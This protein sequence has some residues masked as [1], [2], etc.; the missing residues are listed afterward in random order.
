MKA[1]EF[2]A[3]AKL[4][5]DS[6]TLYVKG[7]F[8]APLNTKNKQRY[9][10]NNKY[11]ISRA[12]MINSASSDTFAFDCVCFIK[13]II[14]GWNADVN[15]QY[16]GAIYQSNNL[17]DVGVETLFN[18]C[19]NISK[20]FSGIVPGAMLYMTGH[21]GI[22]IGDGLAIEASPKWK[23][24]VQVTAVENVAK[25]TNYNSRSWLKWGKL[26]YVEYPVIDEGYEQFKK[27]MN[28]YLKE[29]AELPAD[30]YAKIALEWAQE[31]GIIEGSKEGLMPQS[32]AKR[33]DVVLMLYRAEE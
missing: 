9:S 3:K 27:Y 20:D 30:D 7:A 6:K 28:Q 13:G 33:E 18:S 23:N 17:P 1:E 22:Y 12:K 19:T 31:T 15:K 21:C 2:I 26:P 32:F 11:N 16:G 25:N 5:V 29:R 14:W 8:G 10:N 24:G 4:A